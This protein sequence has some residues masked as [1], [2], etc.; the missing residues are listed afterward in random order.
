MSLQSRLELI[1]KAAEGRSGARLVVALIKAGG[2]TPSDRN[3]TGL[4]R[5][6]RGGILPQRSGW[7]VWPLPSTCL[8]IQV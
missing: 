8:E 4:V 6:F 1:R 7:T 2:E 5:L 3:L